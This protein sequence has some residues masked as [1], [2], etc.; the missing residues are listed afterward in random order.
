MTFE[1]SENKDYVGRALE[2]TIHVGLLIV[3]VAA[4]LLILRPFLLLIAWGSVVAIAVY[5][6]YLKLRGVLGGRGTLAAVLCTVLLLAVLFC[7]S[8]C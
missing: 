5:P 4:C 6:G 7:Q 1:Q 8:L 2:V 3:F